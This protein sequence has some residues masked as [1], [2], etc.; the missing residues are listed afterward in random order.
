MT[1][2]EPRQSHG[3]EGIQKAAS[4]VRRGPKRW[5]N[6]AGSVSVSPQSCLRPE[7]VDHVR[8]VM[9]ALPNDGKVRMAGSG[10]SFTP[11]VPTD[12]TLLLPSDFKED[13]GIDSQRMIAR[14]PAGMV[15]HEANMRL[16]AAGFAL[17]NMG[18]ITAQTVAGS[19]STSTHGTGRNFTGLAGQVAGFSLVTAAGEWLHCNEQENSDIFRLG[20]V[21]LGA[22]GIFTHV[23]MRIVPAFRLR[24]VEEPRRLDDVLNNVD[25]IIDEADHFEFY[26]VP[27]TRW[28][29]TKHNTRTQDPAAPRAPFKKW[30]NKTLL[31]NYAFGAVCAL[32]KVVPSMIPRLA[33]ALPSSGRQ[34][35]VE[36]SHDVFA[37]RRLVRFH[38]ME[39]SI[40]REHLSN[41][42]RSIVEMVN[43]EG[44]KV[45]FPVEVRVTG[46]DDVALST[47]Y[48]R[49]S[50]YIAVHMYKGM[51]YEQ[52]FRRVEEV[53]APLEGRPH[54]GKMH[55]Q[56][57]STLRD[58][59]PLFNE[60]RALRDR[61]DPH[62]RFVNSYV[63][64]VLG[65]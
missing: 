10:H 26:W 59:Y 12:H 30:F 42:L 58:R 32:G 49:E 37:T 4:P 36:T 22:L 3:A 50:A 45:S 28:A 53:L 47:S 8:D 51:P 6:W 63:S 61:L 46:A 23:E 39:Y 17:A 64:R 18:D 5:K 41:A 44:F 60:F 15:L 7:S 25:S 43:R 21:S 55:F 24:A 13:V 11:I 9:L 57:F 27:H 1:V 56:N 48:G 38:E 31:E 52:Y 16:A 40:P 35:F 62:Q 54:W 33:T 20:R 34:E 19:I 14:I 29:L 65:V 2:T